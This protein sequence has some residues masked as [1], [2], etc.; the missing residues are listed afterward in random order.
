MGFATT[1]ICDANEDLISKGQ[2]RVC[3]PVFKAYGGLSRFKGAAVTL[4]V[5]ED[6]TWVRTLL[7]EPG[8]GRV[9]V[10]DGGG[11]TRCALVGGN[12]GVLA[13]KNNW[14]GIVVFGCV[15]DTLELAQSK[16]GIRALAT[17]PQKSVKR[18]VGERDLV[19]DIAGTVVKPG[20]MIYADED[21]VIVSDK[22]LI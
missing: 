19:I 8:Q 17:H 21:G 4:K 16:V 13:E 6:N 1:D 18:N 3:A 12:L 2:L 10:I 14:A 9:L 20:D 22:A 11:S 5:F 7:D 15:R